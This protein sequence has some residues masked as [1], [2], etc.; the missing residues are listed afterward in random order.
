[1]N[2][3]I[4]GINGFVGSHLAE[5]CLKQGA[6]VYGLC[7]Q[8]ADLTNLASVYHDLHIVY[9]DLNHIHE[10][11]QA[12]D[13]SQPDLVFHL[14]SQTSV[15]LSWQNPQETLFNNINGALN[16]LEALCGSQAKIHIAGSSAVYGLSTKLV[17]P[18]KEEDP[19]LP[20]SPY[21][22]SKATQE[23]LA[24][25]Y[26]HT[27]NLH[28]VCTRAFHH[29]GPRQS[30]RY[31]LADFAKQIAAIEAKQQDPVIKTGDLSCQRDYCDVRDVVEAYWL[32]L[33]NPNTRNQVYNV[34]SGQSLSME[35]ILQEMLNLS[36]VKI[37][38]EQDPS[39]MRSHKEVNIICGDTKK[40]EKTIGWK[41]QISLPIML[42]D[43]LNYWRTPGDKAK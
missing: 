40:I 4:T 28:I 13:C 5:Y 26:G 11:R 6:K 41:R 38:V 12:L 14:A 27:Q 8:S 10:V 37:K 39:K 2:V 7:R 43:L 3:F 9:G 22:V 18:F 34:C 16:L 31:A 29:T 36:H 24:W 32:L 1:M 30:H 17:K 33:N 20:L 25:Q 23:L 42:S 15:P 21:G 35:K 19:L